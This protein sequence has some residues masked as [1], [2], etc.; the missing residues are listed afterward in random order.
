MQ[1]S[2][3]RVHDTVHADRMIARTFRHGRAGRLS[4]LALAM[5]LLALP[6]AAFAQQARPIEQDMTPQEF[7][8]AG[9]DK[10]TPD[11]LAKL[12]AWLGRRIETATT[13][14]EALTK[15]R[16]EQEN[17]GFLPFGSSEPI[18]ARLDGEFRGF[19]RGREY[20]LENGQVW[21][22]VDDTSL[23]GVRRSNPGVRLTPS[24]IGRVWYMAI[25]GS[26]TRAKVERVR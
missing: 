12:N 9:L 11:E 23:V 1:A 13:T 15:D 14:A 20:T 16:I 26:N 6:H 22:Q 10:L 5:A 19:Q 24:R 25:E 8:A 17:R 7:Q 3:P 21:R 4:A 2:A 18:E